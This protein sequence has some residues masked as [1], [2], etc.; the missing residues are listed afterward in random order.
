MELSFLIYANFLGSVYTMMEI[1]QTLPD[2][3]SIAS[4][5]FNEVY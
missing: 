1:L 4:I 5:L 3:F 2:I